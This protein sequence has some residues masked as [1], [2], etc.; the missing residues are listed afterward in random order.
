MKRLSFFILI[1]SLVLLLFSEDKELDLKS[2]TIKDVDLIKDLNALALEYLDDTPEIT[3]K[4][5]TQALELSRKFQKPYEECN[6]LN[7]I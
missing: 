5:S 6:S 2:V 1:L 3:I 7:Y 4:Y